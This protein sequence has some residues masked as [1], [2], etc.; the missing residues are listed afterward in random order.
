MND[1]E[2]LHR[3][4]DEE[5]AA[6]VPFEDILRS[7]NLT[8]A[9]ALTC[10]ENFRSRF[11]GSLERY[12][13]RTDDLSSIAGDVCRLFRHDRSGEA[14]FLYTA[15]LTEKGV[16]SGN[17]TDDEQLVLLWLE[18]DEKV[19]KL[20]EMIA[21]SPEYEKRLE[22]LKSVRV[23]NTSAEGEP[24]ETVLLY[25][26]LLQHKFLSDGCDRDILLEN[27]A[28]LVRSV[29]SDERFRLIKPYIYSAILSRKHKMMKVRKN[30]SPNLSEAFKYTGYKIGEDNGKNFDTYQSYLE[31]YEQLRRHYS[32]DCDIGFSDYCFAELSNLSEW[33]YEN[34]EPN[35]DIPMTLEY[36]FTYY[37][38]DI[39]LAY[40]G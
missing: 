40:R 22:Q 7:K 37:A 20:T 19:R 24:E 18:H 16:L 13:L 15:L 14:V 5:A 8:K 10:A 4:L 26:M 32:D 3:W 25:Q 31:L 9:E 12:G 36:A 11:F 33:Y 17:I 21:L 34:C 38:G 39:G 1:Y 30:Y 23:K 28:E 29:E 6:N 2:Y 35:E 27:T